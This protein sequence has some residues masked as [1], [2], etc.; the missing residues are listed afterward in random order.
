[1]Y[2][3]LYVR[4]WVVVREDMSGILILWDLRV[5][6]SLTSR[7]TSLKLKLKYFHRCQFLLSPEHSFFGHA[8][9]KKT[10]K[11]KI[12]NFTVDLTC[13]VPKGAY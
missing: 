9:F 12:P 10:K 2:V 3:C 4:R 11:M 1:M 13:R 6:S 7:I 8:L 5:R